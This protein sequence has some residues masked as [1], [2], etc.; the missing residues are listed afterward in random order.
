MG[1]LEKLA[2][3]LQ[4]RG[5]ATKVGTLNETWEGVIEMRERLATK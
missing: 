1:F 2:T 4:T 5:L 3:N